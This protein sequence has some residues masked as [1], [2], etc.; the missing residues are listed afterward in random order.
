MIQ[1]NTPTRDA[2]D[3]AGG[4]RSMEQRHG[5]VHYDHGWSNT[6]HAWRRYAAAVG[7]VVA[8]VAVPMVFMPTLGTRFPFIT[9]FPAVILAALFGGRGPGALASPV[10]SLTWSSRFQWQNFATPL[11]HFR[12]PR[13]CPFLMA[14]FQLV[15]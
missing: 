4:V 9:L 11:P 13:I 12:Q 14:S 7:I 8:S 2:D 10:S 6:R 3:Q 1:K 15:G 5:V